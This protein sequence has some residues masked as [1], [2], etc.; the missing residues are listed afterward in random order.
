MRPWAA[1][2]PRAVRAA[3]FARRVASK[4]G[5][6][7]P[8]PTG[9]AARPASRRFRVCSCDWVCCTRSVSS[10]SL[11]IGCTAPQRVQRPVTGAAP[12]ALLFR[13]GCFVRPWAAARPRAVRAASFARRV[14]SKP[15]QA[16]LLPTGTAAWHRD[17][18]DPPAPSAPAVVGVLHYT[19]P[20]GGVSSACRRLVSCNS[21]DWRRRGR[22]LRRCGAQIADHFGEKR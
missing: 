2:R 6:A 17:P 22:D 1:A 10:A 8:P 21:P 14:A 7:Q 4:P 15:G 11:L 16:P 5:Q 18:P 19:T 13:P 3:S 20:S 12:L 9:T